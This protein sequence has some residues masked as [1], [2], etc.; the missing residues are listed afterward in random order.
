MLKIIVHSTASE[1][2]ASEEEKLTAMVESLKKAAISASNKFRNSLTKKGRRSSK[3]MSVEI[4]DVHDADEL[5]A[6]DA[7]RQALILEELLPEKHDDYHMLLRLFCV[8]F[9][10]WCCRLFT[11]FYVSPWLM[12]P[13]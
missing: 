3:V 8:L 9:H 5:Q 6:V 1:I 13:N 10:L 12:S 4:E 11:L 7:L 2:D